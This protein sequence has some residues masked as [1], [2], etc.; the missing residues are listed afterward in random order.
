MSEDLPA[1]AA[2]AAGENSPVGRPASW[3]AP[4]V[5]A[6]VAVLAWLHTCSAGLL[7]DAR[8]L[9]EENTFLRHWGDLPGNLSHDYFWS[10]SGNTIP[11]WRP[12]T[13]A[14]WL[15][16]YIA[17]GGKPWVFHAVQVSWWAVAAAAVA[18]LAMELGASVPIAALAG[19]A[20]ALHPAADEPVSLVMARSDVVC[21]AASL[22]A[23]V[24]LLRG[25]RL[26]HAGWLGTSVVAFGVALGSKE[27]AIA[28]LPILGLLAWQRAP[29]APRWSWLR[30]VL[31]HA[32]VALVWVVL[33]AL[34][35]GPRPGAHI[36]WDPL[37]IVAGLGRYAAGVLP[38]R[39]ETGV[40]NLPRAWAAEPSL[41]LPGALALAAVTALGWFAL[42]KRAA[43]AAV[44]LWG[45]LSLLP[46]LLVDELNVPGVQGKIPMADRWLLPLA[47]AVQVALAVAIAGLGPARKVALLAWSA[48]CLGRA[49]MLWAQPDWYQSELHMLD[50]E[51]VRDDGVPS[52]YR[53]DQDRC[54]R[55][56]RA[57]VRAGQQGRPRDV[58]PLV[59]AMPEACRAEP[60]PQFNLL[61]ALVATQQFDQAVPVGRALLQKPPEDRRFHGPLRALLGTALAQTGH[62]AEAIA[63]LEAALQ[64]GAGGCDVP[65]LLGRA[66]VEA[67]RA[68]DGGK[69]LEQAARCLRRHRMPSGPLWILAA[70]AYAT[71]SQLGPAR[72]ALG[73]AGRDPAP[74]PPEL[75]KAYL[76]LGKSLLAPEVA[77]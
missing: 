58:I 63:L 8:F 50:L 27:A 57:V 59:Q 23:I 51:D 44:V 34:A 64:S 43:W 11:Y 53:S 46:V 32:A 75:R 39:P 20:A 54:R 52:A 66:L 10:S 31:P 48:W 7:A 33:R 25:L 65:A 40:L 24:G 28:V 68:A 56:T 67:G 74:L 55:Q 26:A 19:A 5:G 6:A 4:L 69:S 1:A 76:D 41:W 73:E 38:G 16:E 36:V 60:E 77:P 49:G 9:I 71:G 70:Q 30:A 62:G 14:S 2:S 17:S 61:A 47:V 42:R 15:L 18:V 45:A 72:R 37:R 22:W 21:V 35:L 12:L 29:T 13:K 3:L